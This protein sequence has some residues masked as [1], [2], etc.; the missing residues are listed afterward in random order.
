MAFS[1]VSLSCC[2][3]EKSTI[4]NVRSTCVLEA[5]HGSF[6]SDLPSMIAVGYRSENEQNAWGMAGDDYNHV[7]EDVVWERC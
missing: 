2:S 3:R 4:K 6:V 1:S 7:H 5:Y